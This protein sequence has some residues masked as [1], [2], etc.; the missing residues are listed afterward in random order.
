[1]TTHTHKITYTQYADAM[2]ALTS[3]VETLASIGESAGMLA[4][5][6]YRQSSAE[7]TEAR[8]KSRALCG[9]ILGTIDFQI[10]NHATGCQMTDG[11]ELDSEDMRNAYRD[12]WEGK[13]I[14]LL[15]S[16]D[17]DDRKADAERAAGVPPM[18]NG[19]IQSLL[20]ALPGRNLPTRENPPV[21]SDDEPEHWGM[22]L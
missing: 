10:E 1:M 21:R 8:N 5:I 16:I 12:M 4:S 2:I 14:S 6:G 7:M 18:D 17:E 9:M 19:G 20:S 11:C 22:Y 15:R 13:I 3:F